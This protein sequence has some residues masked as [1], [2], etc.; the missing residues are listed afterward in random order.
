MRK[1]RPTNWLV[2]FAGSAA[3]H[4]CLVA[5]L[6]AAG[7]TAPGAA[8]LAPDA[9]SAVIALT[10]VD[11]SYAGPDS[12]AAAI[13]VDVAPPDRA[14]DAH[15]SDRDSLVT[16]SAAPSTSDGRRRGAAPARPREE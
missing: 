8:G 12:L 9:G 11:P 4:G 13:P 14:W 6:F 10:T 16:L 1:R 2:G 7:R 3:V 5:A 15:E